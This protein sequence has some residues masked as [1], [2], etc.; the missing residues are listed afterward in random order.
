MPDPGGASVSKASILI[1]SYNIT[2]HSIISLTF[3]KDMPLK[4]VIP[5]NNLSDVFEKH[6]IETSLHNVIFK[7][8]FHQSLHM[9]SLVKYAMTSKMGHMKISRRVDSKWSN[10]ALVFI[11]FTIKCSN[12]IGLLLLWGPGAVV[13]MHLLLTLFKCFN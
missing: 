13:V 5:L 2:F 1:H 4:Q 3:L 7:M 10:Y 8:S 12:I 9:W 6:A 11:T